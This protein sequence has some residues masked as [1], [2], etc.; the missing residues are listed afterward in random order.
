MK[1]KISKPM[2]TTQ[3]AE[4][5]ALAVLPDDAIDTSDAP[6]LADWSGAKRGLFYPPVNNNRGGREVQ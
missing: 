6:E 2:T 4:L 3:L 5:T 1:Q